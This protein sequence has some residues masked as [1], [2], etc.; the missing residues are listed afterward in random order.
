[1]A[2]QNAATWNTKKI[3]MD[4]IKVSQLWA[5]WTAT[6]HTEQQ[7]V[8]FI[9]RLKMKHVKDEPIPVAPVAPAIPMPGMPPPISNPGGLAA[10]L[11]SFNSNVMQQPLPPATQPE[12]PKSGNGE[13][14]EDKL[15]A[16][17]HAP[18]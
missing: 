2:T 1:M 12:P 16:P 7:L 18:A 14:K 5:N 6:G 9:N 11:H 15:E 8:N 10:A 3:V 13:D 17:P 4:A